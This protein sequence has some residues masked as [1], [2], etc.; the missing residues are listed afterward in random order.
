MRRRAAGECVASPTADPV[1]SGG[2]YPSVRDQGPPGVLEPAPVAVPRRWS[3]VGRNVVL[4]GLTSL[5]TDVSSEALTA[6]LPLYLM[7]ELRMTPLQFG[8]LDGLYQGA[9]ALV[10][11]AGGLVADA[12]RRYKP[13]AFVGYALSALV[14]ARP[15]AGRLGLGADRRAADARPTRQGRPHGPRDALITLSSEP[16]RLGEAFGVHRSD[17][18]RRRGPRAGPRLRGAGRGAGGLR[19]GVRRELRGGPGRP[20]APRTLRREPARRPRPARMARTAR[21]ACEPPFAA[22]RFRALVAAGRPPR[23]R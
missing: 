12:G 23:P 8:L 18:H 17:R 2:V 19:R 20:R 21:A 7:L 6:V 13:V 10:R 4:L 22:A 15:A 16:A 11:V 9:S 1:S 5:F 3:A 14:Q